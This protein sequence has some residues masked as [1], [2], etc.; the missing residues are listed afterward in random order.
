MPSSHRK[1]MAFQDESAHV[2][3]IEALKH[4]SGQAPFPPSPAHPGAWASSLLLRSQ[5]G[6]SCP[7][8][9]PK[10]EQPNS[11][12]SWVTLFRSPC[13]SFQSRNLKNRSCFRTRWES[14]QQLPKQAYF[15]LL[16]WLSHTQVGLETTHFWYQLW[17]VSSIWCFS[18]E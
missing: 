18:E 6:P 5:A 10:S 3:L 1:I 12:R 14:L 15:H 11:R 7:S 8:K 17:I 4:E 13:I 2:L 16:G 9:P